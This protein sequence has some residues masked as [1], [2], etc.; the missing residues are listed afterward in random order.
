VVYYIRN[1]DFVINPSCI[2]S[3]IYCFAVTRRKFNCNSSYLCALDL[4]RRFKNVFSNF[5]IDFGWLGYSG[6]TNLRE[7]LPPFV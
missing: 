7:S 1:Y 2:H 4:N 5:C 3:Y 6:K